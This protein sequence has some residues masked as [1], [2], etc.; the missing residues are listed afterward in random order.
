[1]DFYERMNFNV[2]FNWKIEWEEF[3]AVSFTDNGQHQAY[4][5]DQKRDFELYNNANTFTVDTLQ[6]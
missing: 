4:K 5:S 3:G 1:M 6:R 2:F